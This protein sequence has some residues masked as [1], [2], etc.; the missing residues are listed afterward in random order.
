[1]AIVMEVEKTKAP[2]VRTSGMNTIK[3]ALLDDRREPLF[4][5]ELIRDSISVETSTSALCAVFGGSDGQ[6]GC[7]A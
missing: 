5:D 4:F 3:H 1:M 7:F 6:S 2:Q